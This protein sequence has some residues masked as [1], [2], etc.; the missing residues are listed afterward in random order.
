MNNRDF[1][2]LDRIINKQP[3]RMMS[4]P[5]EWMLTF[6]FIFSVGVVAHVF[7]RCFYE[8]IHMYK[9]TGETVGGERFRLYTDSNIQA[10]GINL[11]RGT[12]WKKDP[13]GKWKIIK[14]VW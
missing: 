11:F 12:V 13:E 9:V 2:D 1:K 8:D 4:A 5:F 6:F 10:L 14:R 3:R 7:F